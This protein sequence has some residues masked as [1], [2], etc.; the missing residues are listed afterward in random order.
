M[1]SDM[2]DK[3]QAIDQFWNSFGW[4]AYDEGTVKKDARLPYITYTV[5]TGSIGGLVVLNASL[6][7]CSRSWERVDNKAEEIAEAL[8]NMQP[9]TIQL[10]HGRL[11]LTPGTPFAQRMTD[12]EDNIRRVYINIYAEYLTAY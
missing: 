3:T 6:W 4:E 9:C 7:D 8:Y 2:P 10:N 5:A 12:P 11:H 1:Y